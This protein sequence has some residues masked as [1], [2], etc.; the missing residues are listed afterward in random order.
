MERPRP[1]DVIMPH[2]GRVRTV[3]LLDDSPTVRSLIKVFLMGRSLEFIETTDGHRALH[4]ARLTRIDLAIVDVNMPRMDGLTFVRLLRNDEREL[5]RRVPVML[6]TGERDPELRR[7]GLLAGADTFLQKP[8]S[9]AG[10]A[11]AFDQ[12]LPSP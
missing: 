3:L 7:Q 2:R 6:L 8:V 11:A 4:L 10:L 5:K 1:Q 9:S 12:L